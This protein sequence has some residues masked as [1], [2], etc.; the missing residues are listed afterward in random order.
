MS[1]YCW[2][3]TTA[4]WAVLNSCA[5]SRLMAVTLDTILRKFMSISLLS[6]V[7]R[8]ARFPRRPRRYGLFFLLALPA[9]DKRF[10]LERERGA[11]RHHW[12]EQTPLRAIIA[13]H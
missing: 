5:T 9:D 1:R 11:T 2:V 4:A 10:Q 6:H 13:R 7:V 8:P 12:P 3:C